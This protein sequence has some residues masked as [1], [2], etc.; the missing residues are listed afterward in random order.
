M[1]LCFRPNAAAQ[2]AP[3]FE[4]GERVVEAVA[5]FSVPSGRSDVLDGLSLGVGR[6]AALRLEFNRID[7]ASVDGDRV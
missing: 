4:R 6:P 2:Q 5:D 3:A 7:L 1:S